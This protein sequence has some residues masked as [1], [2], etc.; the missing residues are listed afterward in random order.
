MSLGTHYTLDK[1]INYRFFINNSYN[2]VCSKSL[3]DVY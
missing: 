2:F 3:E 1:Q